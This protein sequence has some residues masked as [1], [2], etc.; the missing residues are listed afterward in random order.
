MYPVG[1]R[2]RGVGISSD[3]SSNELQIQP[4][5]QVRYRHQSGTASVD[6]RNHRNTDEWEIYSISCF[7][8]V[9][10]PPPVWSRLGILSIVSRHG[11][12]FCSL[13]LRYC[14][15]LR[16]VCA[17]ASFPVRYCHRPKSFRVS[18]GSSQ[19]HGQGRT[20]LN[21]CFQEV[22]L[23]GPILQ[24]FVLPLTKEKGKE[25]GPDRYE[26]PHNY[27]PLCLHLGARTYKMCES[28]CS[29]MSARTTEVK[30]EEST[31]K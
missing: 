28:A 11:S 7:K 29:T 15:S 26:V 25:S 14:T 10:C 5:R 16:A 24:S 8:C 31:F 27:S 19:R 12:L 21:I 1:M 17:W 23:G 13:M 22:S 30:Q 2:T 20:R 4:Q 9:Q 18:K 3:G 6:H